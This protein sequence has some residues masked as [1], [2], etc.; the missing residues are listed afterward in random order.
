VLKKCAERLAGFGGGWVVEVHEV[1]GGW[2][3]LKIVCTMI[4]SVWIS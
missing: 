4:S 3:R 1:L 2:L